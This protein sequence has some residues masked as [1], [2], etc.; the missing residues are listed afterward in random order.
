M[1]EH[2]VHVAYSGDMVLSEVTAV[3]AAEAMRHGSSL[4]GITSPL[5]QRLLSAAAAHEV[6]S[7]VLAARSHKGQYMYMPALPANFAPA[8][9]QCAC[10]KAIPCAGLRGCMGS[11]GCHG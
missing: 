6:R 2:A 7:P 1:E 3:Q 4:S 10:H 8:N 5:L 9:M 11:A